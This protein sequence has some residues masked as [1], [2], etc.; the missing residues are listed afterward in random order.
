[1]TPQTIL[2]LGGSG[3][4][5]R[6]LVA[7]AV[8]AGHHVIIPTRS[9][10]RAK[11]LIL[12][13]TVD[14]LEADIHDEGT[15]SRLISR[16]D[17]VV[18]LVGVLNES[19]AGN[20]DRAH[21]EL[22]RKVVAACG[23]VGVRRLLH[24]S[25]LNAD[26]KGPSHY[27]RSKG[28]AEAIVAASG[29]AW[30]IFRPSV[31]FG[32]ED[33]FLNL[34]ATL[35]RYLPIVALGCADARFQ[36]VYVGDV[37]SAIL[38]SMTDDATLGQYYSLCGPKAYT[39]R[40]LVAYVGVLSGHR[41]PIVALGPTLANLQARVLEMLPGSLMSRD[42]VAS[43]QKDSVCD[44]PYPAPFGGAPTALEAIAPQYLAPGAIRSHFDEFRAQ[45]GR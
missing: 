24:M 21:V 18:N 27:L 29:L 14:V 31:I 36:P 7:T 2:V 35:Q 15:L 8:A 26:S 12:L 23:G 19:P 22:A 13:P 32:R 1:M 37:A 39:L 40:E 16:A 20:F 6:H 10:E 3:F 17:V 44:R 43:M 34:F 28:E 33:A 42:N 5:G 11:H 9:R 30:T 25:A 4:V 45:S 38:R 41:R